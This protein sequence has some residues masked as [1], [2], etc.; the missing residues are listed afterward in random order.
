MSET[1]E[2]KVATKATKTEAVKAETPKTEAKSEPKVMSAE[3]CQKL[4]EELRDRFTGYAKSGLKVVTCDRPDKKGKDLIA[5]TKSG[6]SR[7]DHEIL[8]A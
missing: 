8:K 2:S 6:R 7:L 1:I 5:Y 3:D 4:P